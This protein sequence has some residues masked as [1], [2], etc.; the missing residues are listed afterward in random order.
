MELAVIKALKPEILSLFKN[1]AKEI[2]N[3][4]KKK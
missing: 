2:I 3:N 1:K 4:I